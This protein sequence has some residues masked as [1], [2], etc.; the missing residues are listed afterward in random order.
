MNVRI[1]EPVH[2][3]SYLRFSPF[4]IERKTFLV[5]QVGSFLL[6]YIGQLRDKTYT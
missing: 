2:D 4:L 1:V 6:F 3:E 5:R